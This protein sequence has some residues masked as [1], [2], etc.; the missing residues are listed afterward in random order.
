MAFPPSSRRVLLLG[1]GVLLAACPDDAVTPIDT[2]PGTT[3]ATT[4]DTESG[5]MPGSQRSCTCPDGGEGIEVCQADGQG[6]SSCECDGS[7]SQGMDSTT[8]E[9]TGD[10]TAGEESTGPGG[11]V[12]DEDCPARSGECWQGVCNEDGTCS[13]QWV[14]PGTPCGDATDDECTAP[15]TCAGSECLPN[16]APDGTSC[17]DCPSG[18][19]ACAAGACGECSAFAPVNTFT[20]DR[21]IQGWT[22]TG[23]WALVRQTPQSQLE[24]QSVFPG[25][26]LGSDGNRTAPFPGSETETSYARTPPIVLPASLGFLSWHVDEGG[27]ASDNKTV[28][29]STDGGM[30]WDTL[31]DCAVDPSYPFC[32]YRDTANPAVWVPVAV[33]VPPALQ[34]QT[35]IVEFGYDTVDSCCE[36]EKG[37]YIDFLNF[38]TECACAADSDCA[39]HTST[40]GTG[41][42]QPSGE[43]G[44]DPMPDDTACG[45]PFDND[46]NGAD[47][48][49][50]LGYCRDNE[51]AN[52]LSLCGDCPS[53]ACSFCDNGQC[54]DC[55]SFTDNGD[56]SDPMGVAGWQVT[57]ISGT[58]DWGLYD[59][60]PPNENVGSLP[61][62]FPNAPVYGTDG[63]RNP[64][65]PGSEAEHSQVVT[66]TAVV[67][68]EITFI[69]W[70][71]DEG[72]FFDTKRIEISVDGGMSWDTIVD[73]SAG[74]L[75]PFCMFVADG[76]AADDWDLVTLDTAMWMGQAGQLRFTYETGD[77]CCGFERGWYIDDLSFASFCND[78]PFPP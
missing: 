46:C 28:R 38:A 25:Q 5:C 33:P 52:G 24:V 49:D 61:V 9:P 18:Q 7:T 78:D 73:C 56:F 75:Q 57:S 2:E 54:L 42:C 48:C 19:C 12:T 14:A 22:L 34:G 27:G 66:T 16:H 55:M 41:I 21:S 74:A 36:F 43:C 60:A 77:S 51:G 26:V 3:G 32:E 17:G 37:W 76:R 29:V 1:V 31:A 30:S 11:C 72:D 63:N 39:A 53:A 4:S 59:E 10:S 50:G 58:A 6:F 65:Y 71:V 13:E 23:S 62:P 20:T 47:T 67:P 68:A 40:C 8:S 64:P 15:D 44:L 45:D 70:N 69:S 35:A